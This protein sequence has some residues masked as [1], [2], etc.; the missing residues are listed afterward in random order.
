MFA[1]YE[2]MKGQAFLREWTM[3]ISFLVMML[4]ILLLFFTSMSIF[5]F[6]STP[7]LLM[8]IIKPLNDTHWDMWGFFCGLLLV[9]IGVLAF[10]DKIIK[11]LEFKRLL[12]SPSRATFI[13][14]RDRLEFLAWR[15]TKQ[16]EKELEEKLDDWKIKY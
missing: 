15:L 13:K 12:N 14:N 10:G 5:F 4:G 1:P 16:Q 8:D 11:F 2:I 9:I 6:T 3:E 7:Q